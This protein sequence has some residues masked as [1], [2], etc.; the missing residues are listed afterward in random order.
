LCDNI[1]LIEFIFATCF[2]F[3]QITSSLQMELN[4]LYASFTAR[5]PYFKA[6][7]GKVSIVAHSLGE[8]FILSDKM[9]HMFL[10]KNCGN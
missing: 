2:L 9:V 8:K 1:Y 3:V 5:N 10:K 4:R 7:G 6:N